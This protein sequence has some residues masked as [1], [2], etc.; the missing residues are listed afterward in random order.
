VQG[1]GGLAEFGIGAGE[2]GGGGGLLCRG[3]DGGAVM[4]EIR[5]LRTEEL[6]HLL[7]RRLDTETETFLSNGSFYLHGMNGRQ[8]HRL[9]ARMTEFV[10]TRSGM[11]SRYLEYA[12]R[13]GKGGYEIEHVWAD[14]PEQHEDE[15]AHPSEFT[16]YRNRIGD[17]LLVPKSFNASFGDLPYEEK[18][19]QYDS[20]N[21]L[22]RSLN[23]HA[24]DHNP[25]FLRFLEE[26]S[27]FPVVRSVSQGRPG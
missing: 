20:Q 17:L 13:G 19:P 1:F 10:E 18:L 5:G 22:A 9:L 14:H 16:D 3:G 27:A 2:P 4:R 25:G 11:P 8:I 21:L 24:Y 23:E 7:R 12:K 15:F 26:R 6:A